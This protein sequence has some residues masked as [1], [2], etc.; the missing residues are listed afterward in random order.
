[1]TVECLEVRCKHCEEVACFEDEGQHITMFECK[2]CGRNT[3]ARHRP[4]PAPLPASI[5]DR[6]VATI[7]AMLDAFGNA[8]LILPIK[9][10]LSWLQHVH[11]SAQDTVNYLFGGYRGRKTVMI[12]RKENSAAE[13]LA[14]VA[15]MVEPPICNRQVGSSKLPGSS[16]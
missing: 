12:G 8:A 6:R 10:E 15:Q 2:S 13:K 14:S 11:Q 5:N 9:H 7:L 3:E 16:N 4:D 1:M